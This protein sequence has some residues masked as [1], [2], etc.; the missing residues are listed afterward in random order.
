MKRSS[1]E[2]AGGPRLR[3]RRPAVAGL[4]S[5][6]ATVEVFS[7]VSAVSDPLL[8]APGEAELLTD[9]ADFMMSGLD[10]AD[11]GPVVNSDPTFRD[12]LRRRLWRN[13]VTGYR[14]GG[15]HSTH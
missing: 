5:R 4:P 9:F 12:R 6:A 11:S 8:F 10:E 13:F 2:V 3:D 7:R 14:R 1:L 15:S